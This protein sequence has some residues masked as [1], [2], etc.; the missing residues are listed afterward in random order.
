MQGEISDAVES[1]VLKPATSLRVSKDMENEFK[2]GLMFGD[3]DEVLAGCCNSNISGKVSELR[4]SKL[5]ERAGFSQY[6]ILP[7]KYSFPKTVRIYGY[8]LCF[9]KKARKGRRLMGRLLTESELWFTMFKSEQL[10]HHKQTLIVHTEENMISGDC[11]TKVMNHFTIKK[12]CLQNTDSVQGCVLSEEDLHLALLYL[13]RKSSLEVK[14]FNTQ[15]AIDK[16]AYEKDGIL[17]SK[18]RLL[19]GMNFVETGELGNLN[20]GALGIKV[21]TPVLDRYS[22][23]SYSIAQ[24]IHYDVGKHRG[25][26]T[27]NRIS[28]ENVAIMQ[29]MTLYREIAAECWRCHM[30]RKK[31]LEVSM[32]PIGQEQLMLAPPFYTTMLD[33]FGPVDSYVPGFERNTR[34]RRVLETKMYVMVAVCITTKIVNLQILEG[35]KA[36][37]IIDGFTRLSAEVGVPTVVHVDEDSGA[38]AGFREA[39]LEFRDLQ[40]KLHKQYGISFS[41]CPVSGHHQHGLVE[42]II[43][44]IQETF[45]DL[46]LKQERLH[47]MGWQTFCKLA[48]NSYNNVPFGYSRG[49]EQDN[50]E[51]LKILTPNMLR[52]GR[53]NSRALQGPIRLPANKKELLDHVDKLYSGWFK[54]FT[55]TVVPSLIQQPKWFK[56]DRDLKEQD[57]VYF[58]KRE[59]ALGSPW[60]IG[61]VDQ[62]IVGRDGLIRRAIIKYFNASEN[63]P[64]NGAYH[65]QFTDRAVRKLIRLWSVD[66]CSLFDDLAELQGKHQDTAT[67]DVAAVLVPKLIGYHSEPSLAPAADGSPSLTP[68]TFA[69]PSLAPAP[70]SSPSSTPATFASPSLAPAAEALKNAQDNIG[71]HLEYSYEENT[72]CEVTPLIATS[73]YFA[74]EKFSENE[75][76][77]EGELDGEPDSLVQL[78]LSQGFTLD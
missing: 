14:K 7:T 36:H 23:L 74:V 43:R 40:H 10:S 13:F 77:G 5:E 73:L 31:F 25:I 49:R 48:E 19:E 60:T 47:S 16:I 46:N 12:L 69:S 35:K 78:M 53:L 66:E 65:P 17:L 1:G 68:A 62:V 30:K 63:D 29:G 4:K 18:G 52:V 70:E 42:R 9:I 45:D 51:L 75:D 67:W 59:S 37:N 11:R 28:L 32:G 20:I 54:I 64:E 76:N 34:N 39:E 3:R 26:E 6:I 71:K 58:Q 41:T 57:I 24:H 61:Q 55:D 50:T 2:E 33:L 27:S 22:P 21:N 72:A 15:A 8:V 56:V 38:M 44:S